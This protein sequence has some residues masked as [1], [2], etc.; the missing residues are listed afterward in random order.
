[1]TIVIEETMIRVRIVLK[2]PGHQSGKEGSK[3]VVHSDRERRSIHQYIQIHR[4]EL[5][6][7]C[8]ESEL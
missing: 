7:D 8:E 1:M 5:C 3:C 2:Q 6:C 4:N